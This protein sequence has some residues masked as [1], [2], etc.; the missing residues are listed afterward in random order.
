VTLG[1][2]VA[3]E[4]TAIL[5]CVWV[6]ANVVLKH[7]SSSAPDLGSRS[8]ERVRLRLVCRGKVPLHD[9]PGLVAFSR[10]M[11]W[12][13]LPGVNCYTVTWCGRH[14][15]RAQGDCIK[16]VRGG[17]AAWVRPPAVEGT[18]E[19]SVASTGARTCEKPSAYIIH[20]LALVTPACLHMR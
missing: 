20:E 7:V 13:Q 17:S 6:V 19:P 11:T 4:S 12:S 5:R 10:F 1:D 2:S 3:Q 18:L 15:R 8:S 16:V 9:Q 14:R